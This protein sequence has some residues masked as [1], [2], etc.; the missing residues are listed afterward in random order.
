M[1]PDKIFILEV[2]IAEYPID[3]T[4]FC[5][6][7]RTYEGAKK[8]LNSQSQV[9]TETKYPDVDGTTRYLK[10][11]FVPDPKDAP[12]AFKATITEQELGG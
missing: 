4:V 5:G 9:W 3:Q 1:M 11:D 12:P 10:P 6:A 7:F 8:A 2:T